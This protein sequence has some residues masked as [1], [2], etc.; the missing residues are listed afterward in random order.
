M[1]WLRVLQWW[2]QCG[3]CQ[4]ASK[5][6]TY[7]QYIPIVT[8]SSENNTFDIV[9]YFIDGYRYILTSIHLSTIFPCAIP[10]KD[11]TDETMA[12][13]MLEFLTFHECHKNN[14]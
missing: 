9:G 6:T 5:S 2:E 4:K 14:N 13:S 11:I 8:Q 7:I 1:K 3:R 12:E 10:F